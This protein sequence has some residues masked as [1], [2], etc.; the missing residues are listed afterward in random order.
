M[1]QM[2]LNSKRQ[3]AFAI[4]VL[5]FA[6][7]IACAQ[8]NGSHK[9]DG[10][11]SETTGV[12]WLVSRQCKNINGYQAKPATPGGFSVIF[13][14]AKLDKLGNHCTISGK[15][16]YQ[17]EGATSPKAVD[18]FQGIS[19]HLLVQP[20]E[21]TDW[22]TGVDMDETDSESA[23]LKNDGSFSVAF[24]MRETKRNPIRTQNFQVAISLAR[25]E[26]KAGDV[27]AQEIIWK[28]SQPAISKT[29]Q[30]I[31]IPASPAISQELRLIHQACNWPFHD[32]DATKLIK[33]VNALQPLGKTKALEILKEYVDLTDETFEDHEIA[34]WIIRLLFE[35]VDLEDRIPSPA[36]A[37]VI[38]NDNRENNDVNWPLGPIELVDGIPFMVGQRIGLGGLPEHPITHIRW[39]EQFGVI[40]ESPMRP[41]GNPLLAAKKLMATEKFQALKTSFA[42][43]SKVRHIRGQAFAT[44]GIQIETN[45]YDNPVL[46]DEQWTRSL[47]SDSSRLQWESEG[48]RFSRSNQD[49]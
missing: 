7:Q 21:N 19:I 41:S 40:R 14:P 18:W 15:L 46:T 37:V 8:T 32:P 9:W 24:D 10:T 30:L 20:E 1:I 45:E 13:E 39:V 35:P 28:S 27:S 17:S 31:S 36:I 43:H 4:S 42:G 44:L 49:N 12:S 23:I 11:H 47:S 38:L 3:L 6:S 26:I 48:Q 29:V 34:F 2:T 25:H 33:A 5:L 16:S 22:S